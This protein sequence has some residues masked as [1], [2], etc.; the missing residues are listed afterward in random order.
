MSTN[1]CRLCNSSNTKLTSSISAALIQSLL[2]LIP[3][4]KINTNF[5]LPTSVCQLCCGKAKVS[6]DFIT[7]IQETQDEINKKYKNATV[8][9]AKSTTEE[10]L[11]RI[12]KT[13]G[14]SV[15]RISAVANAEQQNVEY[16]IIEEIDVF[17]NEDEVE[18]LDDDDYTAE[19]EENDIEDDD[20]DYEEPKKSTAKGKRKLVSKKT[21]NSKKNEVSQF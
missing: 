7:K 15:R 21:S 12:K 10:V 2:A 8:S 18:E 13:A 16:N 5:K 9:M 3:Q 20:E 1:V 19:S 6:F 11:E 4:I 14:I 17:S